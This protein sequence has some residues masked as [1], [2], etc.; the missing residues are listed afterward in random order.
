M[1]SATLAPDACEDPEAAAHWRNQQFMIGLRYSLAPLQRY[2]FGEGGQTQSQREVLR[3]W[4]RQFRIEVRRRR[5]TRRCAR[6]TDRRRR[7]RQCAVAKES[8]T[9]KHAVPQ[10]VLPLVGRQDTMGAARA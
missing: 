5:R 4:E 3:M 1:K 7:T 6:Q 2:A 9:A 8:Q 10:A